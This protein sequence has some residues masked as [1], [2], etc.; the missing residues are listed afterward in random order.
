MAN[1]SGRV[2]FAGS[3]FPGSS[4][5]CFLSVQAKTSSRRHPAAIVRLQILMFI[6]LDYKTGIK[7]YNPPKRGVPGLR[8]QMGSFP[9]APAT[10]AG[11]PLQVSGFLTP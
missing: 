7:I 10:A 8:I 6:L 5:L 4:G 2:V 9:G 11:N 3:P 1:P